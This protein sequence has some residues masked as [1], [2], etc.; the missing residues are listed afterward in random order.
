VSRSSLERILNA[1]HANGGSLSRSE[2][3]VEVFRRNKS[4]AKLDAV[5]S[6]PLAGL[7]IV[8]KRTLPPKRRVWVWSLTS[9]GWAR[10]NALEAAKSPLKLNSDELRR[11]L[12]RLVNEQDPWAEAML[13]AKRFW[14]AR[15]KV[16]SQTE[17]IEALTRTW[18][19]SPSHS[20]RM[21]ARRVLRGIDKSL[22]PDPQKRPEPIKKKHASHPLSES[23]IARLNAVR[24]RL[25]E[26]PIGVPRS[27]LETATREPEQTLAT[28]PLK[29]PPLGG[30]YNPVAWPG[31]STQSPLLAK[32]Q[33]AG[34]TVNARGEVLYDCDKWIPATEWAK[35]MDWTSDGPQ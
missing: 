31:Q 25:G 12:V 17:L 29:L 34:Y 23:D 20:D 7:V 4:A 18:K 35:R 3:S 13:E 30:G 27:P 21:F 1:L 6:G 26:E 14:D 9:E 2:I 8:E 11:Q 10:V 16:L 32:I 19:E 5:L 15:S 24:E 22:A 28:Q 33:K